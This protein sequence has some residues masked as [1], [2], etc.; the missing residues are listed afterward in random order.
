MALS[1][2]QTSLTSSAGHGRGGKVK[3]D[4][5]PWALL[6]AVCVGGPFPLGSKSVGS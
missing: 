3:S 2:W 6:A 1:T 5:D 4:M